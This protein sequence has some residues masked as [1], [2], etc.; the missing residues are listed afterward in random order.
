M[1]TIRKIH[2]TDGDRTT[3]V[4]LQEAIAEVEEANKSGFF[5]VDE[6]TEEKRLIKDATGLTENSQVMIFPAV[7]GG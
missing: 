3:T 6:T 2:K 5:V 7:Q 1:V 4:S